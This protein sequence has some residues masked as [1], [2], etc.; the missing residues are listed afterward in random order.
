MEVTHTLRHCCFYG[1]ALTNPC[2]SWCRS[3]DLSGAALGSIAGL[4][5]LKELTIDGLR[6]AQPDALADALAR[7]S[8]LEALTLRGACKGMAVR[9]LN[10]LSSHLCLLEGISTSAAW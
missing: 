6:A 5:R 4:Q 1:H 10:P 3:A 7:M 9:F 8:A 2:T